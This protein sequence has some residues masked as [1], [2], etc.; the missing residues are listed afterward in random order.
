MRSI[1]R[2]FVPWGAAGLLLVLVTA[3]LLV[4]WPGGGADTARASLGLTFSIG[5]IASIDPTAASPTIPLVPTDSAA[6]TPSLD[7][8]ASLVPTAV[9]SRTAS[10]QPKASPAPTATAAPTAA[11]TPP[12]F[13]AL[14]VL[15]A[16]SPGPGQ[17]G[18][19]TGEFDFSF[20]DD[21]R[22]LAE[23][24]SDWLSLK[25]SGRVNLHDGR[26]G[27][28]DAG[29]NPLVSASGAPVAAARTLDFGWTRW[30]IEPP[31][32][33]VDA[34]GNRYSDQSYWNLCGPGTMT[35]ALYYWQQL[36]GRPNVTGTAG[37]FLDPYAAEAVAWP[38][39]GPS[40]AIPAGAIQPLGTYW[41]GTDTAS[42]YRA[43]GRGYMM[44]LAMAAQPPGWASTGIDVFTD[45][46]GHPLYPTRGASPRSILMAINWEVSGHDP[47]G[48]ADAW[49]T[50]VTNVDPTLARDLQMAVMLDVGRDGVPVIAAV[51]SFEL[52]NWQAGPAT[53]HIQHGVTIVGYDNAANPPTYTYIDTCGRSCDNRGGNQN[54]Q[55]HVI[56][57]AAMVRAIRDSGGS[58]FVW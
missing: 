57:Q 22:P 47:S 14:D 29:S 4:R 33:G 48:W 17:A 55:I 7:P 34:K 51:D 13:Y 46:K 24:S 37:Y 6:P 12:A 31:G 3:G 20:V 41:S 19:A 27:L 56:T 54:G 39:A 32:S 8:I 43:N 52:P 21:R 28:L 10:A 15:A 49:Y 2:R 16:P 44:Y 40:F 25:A 18:S 35:A 45:Q 26:I 58:G 53:P 5:R 42:G 36:T 50:S 11:P 9:A 23:Q 38:A 30:V 1:W